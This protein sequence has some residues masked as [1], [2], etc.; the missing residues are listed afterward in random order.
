MPD[1]TA[2]NNLAAGDDVLEADMDAIRGNIEY[3]LEPNYDCNITSGSGYTVT[4]T[5]WAKL[6]AA[7]DISLDTH[8][9][10]V[11][12]LVTLL[13]N[14]A[15][16]G[17]GCWDIAVDGTRL[18]NAN[19]GLAQTPIDTAQPVTFHA[20]SKPVAGTHTISIYVKATAG[21]LTVYNTNGS[22]Q[23]AITFSAIEL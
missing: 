2:M 19:S 12:I 16:S 21:T 11:L 23:P 17:N 14:H 10:P 5:S 3:L 13:A 4:S 22:V 6:D 9:G 8:G 15:S 1:W 18:G 7:L 20:I